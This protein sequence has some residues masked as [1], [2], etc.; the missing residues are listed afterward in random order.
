MS[1]S[2]ARKPSTGRW[3][4]A[5]VALI[6]FALVP[7]KACACLEIY[8]ISQ[9]RIVLSVLLLLILAVVALSPPGRSAVWGAGAGLVACVSSAVAL[10]I[11]SYSL[12]I[13]AAVLVVPLLAVV[14][15][16]AWHRLRGR[17]S[18]SAV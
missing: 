10:A 6:A 12:P 14:L 16:A 15:F 9:L 11:G 8:Q 13:A 5:L 17:R 18:A 1:T 4:A 7:S 3:I 2:T